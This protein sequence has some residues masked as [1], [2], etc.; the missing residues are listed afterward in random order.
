MTLSDLKSYRVGLVKKA[1]ALSKSEASRS[2]HAFWSGAMV[3]PGVKKVVMAKHNLTVSVNQLA[4]LT[5][6]LVNQVIAK[7]AACNDLGY[8]PDPLYDAWSWTPFVDFIQ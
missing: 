7:R 6:Q 5:S 4:G 2:T 3:P 1:E 8:K